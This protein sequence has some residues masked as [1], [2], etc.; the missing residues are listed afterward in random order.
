MHKI[1]GVIIACCM[2]AMLSGCLNP[3]SEKT[4]SHVAYEAE[5]DAVQNAVLAYKKDTGVLPI[6][7]SNEKTPL[8]KKYRIDFNRLIPKYMGK[9]PD[10]AYSEGGHFEY[11]IVNPEHDLQVKVIDLSLVAK[12]QEIKQRVENYRYNKGFSPIGGVIRAKVYKIDFKDIG[13]KEPP[14]VISPYSGQPLSFVMDNESNVYINYLPDI[15]NAYKK[16]GK[17]ANNG[18]DLRYLLLKEHPY[19]PVDSL[20]YTIKNN[21]VVFL[22]K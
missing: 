6:K 14:T 20:P 2:T 18:E 22:V 5:M 1:I 7:N 10:N 17:S 19:V 9:P 15:Y 3:G 4:Q 12:V 11:V 21:Q 8:Y 13:Y 16:S